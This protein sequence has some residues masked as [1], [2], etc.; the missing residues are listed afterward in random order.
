MALKKFLNFT[1]A[2][3][4]EKWLRHEDSCLDIRQ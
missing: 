2:I 3:P 4:K 1:P